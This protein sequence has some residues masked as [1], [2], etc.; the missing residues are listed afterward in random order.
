LLGYVIEVM[1]GDSN[2]KHHYKYAALAASMALAWGT[3]NAQNPARTDR[4]AD[5]AQSLSHEDYLKGEDLRASKLVGARVRNAEGDNLG[6]IEEIVIPSGDQDDMLVIVSV[7]GLLDV[8]DKLVALPYDDLR[9]SPDGDTFYFDRTE[10]QLKAAPEFTYEAQAEAQAR[11]QRQ[12]ERAREPAAT[13]RTTTDRPRT[14]APSAATTAKSAN[15]VLDVFDHRAS[16]LIGATVLDDRGESVGK[17]D[18]IVVSTEDDELHV[19]IAIGGFAGFGAKLITMPLDD[20]QITADDDNP[21]VRIAMTG[22]QLQQLVEA[23]PEF[24]YERQVAQAP[25]NAPRG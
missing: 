9:V 21:Q 4:A 5:F 19:V 10:A 20:L 17:V 3:A 7:G 1:H 13:A 15:V 11:S 12:V 18:D 25:A 14:T 22:D 2:M 6:E 8:G 23:R 24:R 16:D